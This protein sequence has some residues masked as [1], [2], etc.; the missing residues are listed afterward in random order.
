[1]HKVSLNINDLKNAKE[2]ILKANNVLIISHKNPDADAIGSNIALRIAL[3]SLG[4][5]VNSACVDNLPEQ[6]KF[7][8]YTNEFLKKIN[9]DDYDLLIS[10]DCGSRSQVNFNEQIPNLFTAKPFLNIDHHPTN[11]NYGSVNMV[12]PQCAATA[13]LIYYLIKYLGVEMNAEIATYLACGLYYDTG[14][15][16]HS[17]TTP[18][19][20]RIMGDL[21]R[22]GADHNLVVKE[23]FK[24]SSVNKL[25]LWGRAL[26]RAR[27]ND[28]NILISNI[29]NADFKELNLNPDELSGV[30]DY[31]NSVPESK[32][33]ILLAEDQ[34]GNVKGSCRTLRDDIDLS[35][36]TSL[37]GG[38][39]HKKASGF[40]VEGQISEEQ[41][42]ILKIK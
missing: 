24:S 36:I 18:E 31:L 41:V 42:T 25:K 20:L 27:L 4:K 12:D 14:S 30:I 34:K 22:K 35:M 1:M 7:I 19:I 16:K 2:E 17:N 40:S 32:F 39:G 8:K 9:T 3:E 21:M 23:M 26:S 11:E 15:F 33:C 29:T 38:G 28:K 5:N 37:L 10:V 6:L 13:I